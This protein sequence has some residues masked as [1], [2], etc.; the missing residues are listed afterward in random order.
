[1]LRGGCCLHKAS[2]VIGQIRFELHKNNNNI[3]N[4]Q[5]STH[6]TYASHGNTCLLPPSGTVLLAMSREGFSVWQPSGLFARCLVAVGVLFNLFVVS[7]VGSY[8]CFVCCCLFA[9]NASKAAVRLNQTITPTIASWFCIVLFCFI[10]ICFCFL[11][12]VACYC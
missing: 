1:M 2:D 5:Q 9:L 10:F 11:I 6:I 3:N 8:C 4:H 7:F 12:V